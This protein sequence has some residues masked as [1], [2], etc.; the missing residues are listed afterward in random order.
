MHVLLC[1]NHLLA[2]EKDPGM[3]TQPDLHELARAWVKKTYNKPGNVFLEPIHRL[4]KPVGGIVLFARTSKALA[5]LNEQMRN[6]EME[7]IYVATLANS[8]P[9]PEGLLEHYLV[10]DDY[11]ARV[12]PPSH[13]E[14][15]LARLSYR[16][17]SGNTIEITLHTGRYHQIRCQFAAINCPIL[18]DTKYNSPP[19]PTFHL[20]HTRMRFIHPVTGESVRLVGKEEA[21]G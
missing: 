8:P 17:L 16:T 9:S 5:R 11:R 13:P 19:H 12:V 14:A 1:D 10:H 18:G 20:R 6:R 21:K 15:K 7:K 3:A 4:D 2:V